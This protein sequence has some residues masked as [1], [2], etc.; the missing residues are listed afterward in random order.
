MG[1]LGPLTKILCS[2]IKSCLQAVGLLFCIVMFATLCL[3]VP[4]EYQGLVILSVFG[5]STY[6]FRDPPPP[7]KLQPN[8]PPRL[9]RELKFR[10][11][12]LPY[13]L[14]M[15]CRR[16]R[17]QRPRRLD[18]STFPSPRS[19]KYRRWRRRNLR[20]RRR[21]WRRR[22]IDHEFFLQPN[23]SDAGKFKVGGE[24]SDDVLSEFCEHADFLSLPRLIKGLKPQDHE[25]NARK[26]IAKMNLLSLEVRGGRFAKNCG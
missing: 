16:R 6:N 14:V 25:A 22:V 5:G 11:R 7:K 19:S 8:R 1:R 4:S 15:R 18:G 26:A 21:M 23:A 20:S 3:T 2:T 9:K 13:H 10:R 24:I 17:G 12:R